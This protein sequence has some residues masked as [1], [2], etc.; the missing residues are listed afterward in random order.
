LLSVHLIFVKLGKQAQMTII[1]L[2]QNA[3][4]TLFT[5]ARNTQK[6]EYP[7]KSSATVTVTMQHCKMLESFGDNDQ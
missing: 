6:L 5:L 4:Q 3:K 7:H 1:C 2:W